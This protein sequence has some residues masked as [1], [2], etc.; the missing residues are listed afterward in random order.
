MRFHFYVKDCLVRSGSNPQSPE[1]RDIEVWE[2]SLRRILPP[3]SPRYPFLAFWLFHQLRVFRNRDYR[4]LFIKEG[5]RVV[6]R[7][8]LLP[9]FFRYP[10]MRSVD[11]NISTWTHPD[12]RRS[13]LA[14][15]ALA[16]AMNGSSRPSRRIWY[17]TS[18]TNA[19]S[20]R[21]A[22]RRE[23]VFFASGRRVT[24]F[25]SRILG[26]F[27][28]ETLGDGTCADSLR[29][30]FFERISDRTSEIIKR[31]FDLLSAAAGLIVLA[32]VLAALALAVRLGSRGPVLYR[33]LRAG[34]RGKPFRLL[35]FRTMVM[36]ADQIGGPSSSADDPRITRLGGLLRRYK[37]DELPQLLNVL[38]GEMS[39][40]GPR[41]EVLQEVLLYSEAEKRLLEVRPGIT[42]WA[43]IRF[44]NEGEILRGSADPHAAYRVKIR[45]EKIRLGL[46]YVERRSFW[47]DCKI[48]VNTLKAIRE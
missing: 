28:L 41:P 39:L 17:I 19:E 43:S 12:Y 16:Q 4:V 32:P 35:K 25:G 3:D 30:G 2:P 47:T 38:R 11:L 40:V 20:M 45:P 29:P 26:R 24:T 15:R 23:F 13:G 5:N 1:P 44:R 22:E 6:Q 37:L 14:D 8:C 7:C 27:V 36:N 21:L 31:C 9:P 10:F 34:R 46:E 18:E 42:D 48:I 33:G